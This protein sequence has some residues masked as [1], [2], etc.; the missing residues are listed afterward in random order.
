V[1][2]DR[3]EFQFLPRRLPPTTWLKL[4]FVPIGFLLLAIA[5]PAHAQRAQRVS[6]HTTDGVTVAASFFEPSHRPAPAVILV[7]MLTRNRRDWDA[8]AVRLA[9]DG[10]AAL[11]ID[12]RGHGESS[13][14]PSEEAAAPAAMLKDVLAARQYLARR[15][16]V[17][18][19]RIGL[20]GASL[21]ANLAVL[22]GAGDPSIRTLAL[23]SPTLDYRGVRIEAAARKYGARPLLIVASREDAF[24]LRTMKDLTKGDLAANREQVLLDQAGHGTMMFSRDG[25]LIRMLVDWFRRTL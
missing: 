7:H 5:V 14:A 8:V 25:G 1:K 12:L 24:A 20:A 13:A 11:T 18:H 9:S 17:Q 15:P 23:L 19:D 4:K 22:A 10:I 3:D 2:S 21:G 16:D 6:F